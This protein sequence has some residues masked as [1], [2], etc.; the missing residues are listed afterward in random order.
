MRFTQSKRKFCCLRRKTAVKR[1]FFG[2]KSASSA[3]NTGASSSL[4]HSNCSA[5]N[6]LAKVRIL[7]DGEAA[8]I[9]YFTNVLGQQVF[10][11]ERK[12]DQLLPQ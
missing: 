12:S 11:S 3:I 8:S 7:K 9:K 6:R 4:I 2:V 10:K 5:S 1:L